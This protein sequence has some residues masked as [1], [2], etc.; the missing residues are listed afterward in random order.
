MVRVG[1]ALVLTGGTF[2]LSKAVWEA[3]RIWVPVDIPI[4]LSPGHTKTNEFK[5]NLNSPYVV[6]I[7]IDQG[8]DYNQNLCLIGVQQC[9]D[10]PSILRASWILSDA[11]KP[12]AAGIAGSTQ[13]GWFGVW[14]AIFRE[15][16]SF[17]ATKGKHYSLDVDILE[18]ASRLNSA[19]PR[20][21]VQENGQHWLYG[22]LGG[23]FQAVAKIFIF[24]GLFLSAQPIFTKFQERRNPIW[25]SVT[26]P[27]Q[28]E[29]LHIEE[30]LSTI[31]AEPYATNTM[32]LGVF[33]TLLGIVS[34][35]GICHWFVT[36]TFTAD[37]TDILLTI[38]LLISLTGFG[39][40]VLWILP[41]NHIAN[42]RKLRLTGTPSL[43]EYVPFAQTLPLQRKFEGL[44]SFGLLGPITVVVVLVPLWV[45]SQWRVVPV[46]LP[47]SLLKQG[48]AL[49]R[50]D[51][52]TEPIVIQIVDVGAGKPPKIELNSKLF[53]WNDLQHELKEEIARRPPGTIV[54]IVGDENLPWAD[55]LYVIDAARGLQAKV[56]LLGKKIR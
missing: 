5:L 20:L 11:G 52:W 17:T 37:N 27:G 43:R 41:T 30:S 34:F 26:S 9:E 16:G 44:R 14:Q 47:V 35:I 10:E 49:K 46:G 13:R 6:F 31:P 22:P 12:I 21:I 28:K 25:I 19:N 48:D 54:Y 24:F 33:I 39:L 32:W 23:V 53:S 4:S 1:L 56:V 18:D 45:I 29:K 2:F 36:R 51:P 8:V 40:I 38:S 15:V 50:I 7:A 55:V 42:C 3:T